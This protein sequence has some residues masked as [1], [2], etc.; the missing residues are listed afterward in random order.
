[1]FWLR[2][3][4]FWGFLINRCDYRSDVAWKTFVDGWPSRVKRYFAEQYGD[5]DA[6]VVD[7]MLFTVK[8]D[9][10]SL[11]NASI[12]QVH[13]RFSKWIYSDEAQ[14]ERKAAGN[15]LISFPRYDYCVHVDARALDSWLQWLAYAH[16]DDDPFPIGAYLQ[17]S[18]LTPYLNIM[19]AE[20]T[21]SLAEDLTKAVVQ[22]YPEDEEL[23]EDPDDISP[24]S[25]KMELPWV[26]PAV[27]TNMCT[28]NECSNC[29]ET[30]LTSALVTLIDYD[31]WAAW[32]DRDC[33]DVYLP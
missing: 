23:E 1:M 6:D 32:Y 8:D 18:E 4:P 10:S 25:V 33:N 12:H 11:D 31:W 29:F 22:T 15:G 16:E 3:A 14:A 26:L 9:R 5:V 28:L 27:C 13:Q 24:I 20:E 21:L 2:Q 19:R 7:K 17:D 30:L